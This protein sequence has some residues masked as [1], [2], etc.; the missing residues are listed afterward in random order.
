M[1]TGRVGSGRVGPGLFELSRVGSGR[2]GSPLP[3]PRGLTRLVNI[4]VKYRHVNGAPTVSESSLRGELRTSPETLTLNKNNGITPCPTYV[5]TSV[6]TSK[7]IY[8]FHITK[9][10]YSPFCS[11]IDLTDRRG[12]PQGRNFC[13]KY[14]I[15][16]NIRFRIETTLGK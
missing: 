1:T 15:I 5:S 16:K 14:V 12:P 7:R 10:K 4:P 2:V 8:V 9:Q 6:Y 13:E 3:G 11:K